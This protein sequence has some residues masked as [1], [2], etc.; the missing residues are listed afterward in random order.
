MS[1][2][3]KLKKQKNNQ[4]NGKFSS[5]G[6]ENYCEEIKQMSS[7]GNKTDSFQETGANFQNSLVYVPHKSLEKVVSIEMQQFKSF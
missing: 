3:V 5:S 6:K 7:G 4:A 2:S 1:H